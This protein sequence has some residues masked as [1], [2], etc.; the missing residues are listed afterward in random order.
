MTVSTPALLF[1]AISLLLLA[2]TNRFI[3]LAQLIRQL[4]QMETEEDY[5]LVARQLAM[6]H[7]RIL[8]T[9]RMQ[10]T[11][12]L[13][14]F[15]C[16][17][18]MFALFLSWDMLGTISFGASLILLSLSLLFSFWE[19]VISNNAINLELKDFERKH[20]AKLVPDDS[21]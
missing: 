19:I 10:A 14:F 20:K 16:T 7:Q 4:K 21:L 5:P 11:G 3:V 15:L 12:V 13:S 9:K 2:Y 8:L 1:P 18:S 6:L 17:V